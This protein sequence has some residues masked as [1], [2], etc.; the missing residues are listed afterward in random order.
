MALALALALAA[1]AAAGP[2]DSG[3]T[4]GLTKQI[5]GTKCELNKNFGCEPGGGGNFSMWVG[6]GCRGVFECEGAPVQCWSVCKNGRTFCAC[7]AATFQP[8]KPPYA[9][10]KKPTPAPPSPT[11]TPRT[12]F[13][14]VR[15]ENMNGE[16]FRSDTG[17]EAGARFAV[18]PF[19]EYPGGARYFDVYSPAFSTLCEWPL[20]VSEQQLVDAQ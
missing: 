4:V 12:P 5:S 14:P 8:P 11:P 16:Y 10:P 13:V 1:T 9:C 7:K 19:K 2:V 6:G 17:T 3:C 18:R 20:A 15:A